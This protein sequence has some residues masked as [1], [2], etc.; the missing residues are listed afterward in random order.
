[1]EPFSLI[2]LLLFC[3]C[4]WVLAVEVEAIQIT[5]RTARSS[6]ISGIAR[7]LT[8][9]FEDD[10]PS[11]N[12]L[13]WKMAENRYQQQLEK[14]MK[15]LVQ[16]GAQHAL[17]VAVAV[18][19][20]ENNEA[21]AG[22]MELG[23]MPSP[24]PVVAIWEGIETSSRPEMP[25][26][27][28]LAVDKEYRRQKMG[29]KLVQLAI[30]ISLKWCSSSSSSNVEDDDDDDERNAA[31]YLAV[32]KENQA[33]VRLYNRLHFSPIID[34]TEKLSKEAQR[35]LKRKPRIYFEKKLFASDS[36]L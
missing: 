33:A 32:E 3:C 30:K 21:I 1:V 15:G 24:I 23:T 6:D 19:A 29:T 20:D 35:K 13:Q 12:I 22:F 26:L 36:K 11:W 4:Y 16:A 25:Y 34:E 31:I 5:Y 10:I 27:A 7:L 9:T 17:I 8:E 18:A 14:R 2:A 28:N